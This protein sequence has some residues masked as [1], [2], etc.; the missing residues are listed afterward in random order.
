MPAW[1]WSNLLNV[2]IIIAATYQRFWATIE[3][4]SV[5]AVNTQHHFKS[6]RRPARLAAGITQAKYK[7]WGQANGSSSHSFNGLGA[8]KICILI[9]WTIADAYE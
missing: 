7:R 2:F 6:S 4:N 9:G 1:K 5:F 8:R 3:I